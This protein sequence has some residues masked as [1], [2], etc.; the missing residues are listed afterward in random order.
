M[1]HRTVLPSSQVVTW[2]LPVTSP[3]HPQGLMYLRP[4][5]FAPEIAQT[6]TPTPT[7]FCQFSAFLGLLLPRCLQA[8]AHGA[9]R[10]T[11]P[12][13]GLPGFQFSRKGPLSHSTTGTGLQPG[14]SP[15][16]PPAPGPRWSFPN[17][18]EPSIHI[19]LC[20]LLP[21][22]TPQRVR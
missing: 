15:C 3:C 14:P 20:S 6:H 13:V 17:T 11:F 4:Y 19:A 22:A 1:C 7:A 2:V 10:K 5:C 9:Q 21:P 18:L 16:D 8:P 12:K